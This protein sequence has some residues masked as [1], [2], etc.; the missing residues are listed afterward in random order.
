LFAIALL[1]E[2]M[3]TSL[4]GGTFAIVTGVVILTYRGNTTSM[5]PLW[6]LSL[7][8][9]AAILRALAH[10]VTKLGLDVVPE[11]LFAGLVGYSVSLLVGLI[12]ASVQHAR[13]IPSVRWSPGMAWFLI[14]GIINGISLWSLNTAL[15][16]GQVITVV[17]VVSVSPVISFLLGYFIFRKERFTSRIVIAIVLIVPAIVIIARSN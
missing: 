8:L 3:T 17:P 4:M 13:I 2:S 10:A 14:G 9:G 11:P 7:P 5:W 1:E 15:Q 12:V 6:A 16:I